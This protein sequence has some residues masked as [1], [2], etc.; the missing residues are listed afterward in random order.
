V[1]I[2]EG[3]S[4][5]ARIVMTGTSAT[6]TVPLPTTTTIP[7][8][9]TSRFVRLPGGTFTMGSP[10]DEQDRSSDE[11]PQHQV[12]V[13]AFAIGKYVVTFAEYDAYCDATGTVKPSDSGWGRGSRPVINVSWLD[14][15]A[16]CNWLSKKEGLSP[17]YTV[18]GTNVSWNRSANG[19]RLPTEAEWEYASRAGTTTATTF[20]NSLDSTQANFD[21]NY[22]YNTLTKGPYLAKTAPVGSYRPNAWGLYDMHGNAWEW[23]QDWY[24]ESYYAKS[25]SA[26]PEGPDSGSYR[27]LHGGSWYDFGFLLRSATRYNFTP[28]NRNYSCVFRVVR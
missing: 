19:Y 23:C 13:S 20:G 1:T 5:Q 11:G 14:A 10:S 3:Q 27:V 4:S 9:D 26:D 21:G 17:A 25:P 16:Y 7:P 12:R 18:N 15:V 2:R 6:T 24:D 28:G 22:P 8:V